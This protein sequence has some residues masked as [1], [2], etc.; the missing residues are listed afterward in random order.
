LIIGIIIGYF[1]FVTPPP[2]EAIPTKEINMR[3]FQFGYD[4]SII[5]VTEGTKVIIHITEV[6]AN[7]EPGLQSI[8]LL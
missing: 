3:V 4:P 2:T 6:T 8:L 5:N 1:V 7:L